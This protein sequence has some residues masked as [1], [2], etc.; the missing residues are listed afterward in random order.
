MRPRT[1]R[2]TFSPS[3][4]GITSLVHD[5]NFDDYAPNVFEPYIAWLNE[6]HPGVTEELFVEENGVQTPILTEESL[7]LAATYL[8]EYDRFLNG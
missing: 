5:F 6:E 4:F 1:P 2:P 8:D 3:L 7:D